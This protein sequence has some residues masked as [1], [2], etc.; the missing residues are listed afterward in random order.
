ME[1]L[2]GNEVVELHASCMRCLFGHG[3]SIS[4]LLV[5]LVTSCGGLQLGDKATIW[6]L[7]VVVVMCGVSMEAGHHLML[8]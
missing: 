1:F 3:M 6:H 5:V 8:L 2:Q 4:A 7:L